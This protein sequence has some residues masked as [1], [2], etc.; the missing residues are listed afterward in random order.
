MNL[1]DALSTL[2]HS[3]CYIEGIYSGF[4]TIVEI[5][6]YDDYNDN[7]ALAEISHETVDY[8]G[9]DVFNSKNYEEAIKENR[10]WEKLGI[11]KEDVYNAVETISHY[12]KWN[13]DTE[14]IIQED[15]DIQYRILEIN[16]NLKKYRFYEERYL[17]Y[18]L[19]DNDY[20]YYRFL[21]NKIA[22]QI[23]E[24]NIKVKEIENGKTKEKAI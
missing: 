15:L 4:R 7:F 3:R 10:A 2:H 20:E 23:E 8:L 1:K 14:R 18:G 5:R 13:E 24:L 6:I 21:E 19:S 22:E 17:V 11:Y 16:N 9:V 12:F